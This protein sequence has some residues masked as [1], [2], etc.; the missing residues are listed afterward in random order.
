MAEYLCAVCDRSY[1]TLQAP[2]LIKA[3]GLFHC[4]DCDTVLESATDGQ[5]DGLSRRER[6]KAVKAKQAR[7]MTHQNIAWPLRL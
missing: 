5:A 3:D 4:E 6:N 1:T 7:C 2:F